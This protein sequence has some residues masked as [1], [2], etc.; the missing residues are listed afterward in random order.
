MSHSEIKL[1]FKTQERRIYDAFM[2]FEYQQ[3][4]QKSH[5]SQFNQQNTIQKKMS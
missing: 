4:L 2:L 5:I 3:W 1:L